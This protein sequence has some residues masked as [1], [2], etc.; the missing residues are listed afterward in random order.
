METILP[1]KYVFNTNNVLTPDKMHV[2]ILAKTRQR[3]PEIGAPAVLSFYFILFP[4][5][6]I[7]M[8]RLEGI[9]HYLSREAIILNLEFSAIPLLMG[10]FFISS[11]TD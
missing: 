5:V 10:I 2:G 6:E 1:T 7:A 4:V 9:T 8:A 11:N 3:K